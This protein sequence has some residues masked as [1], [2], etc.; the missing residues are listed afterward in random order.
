MMPSAET[1]QG[2][3]VRF[4]PERDTERGG[5][6][7][8]C[9][10][11]VASMHGL[12]VSADRL[13]AG[14]P[15][16]N[17]VL[18]PSCL[19]RD[20]ARAGMVAR[21]VR[22]PL[23]KLNA[24]L[25]PIIL[26]LSENS[27]C[28]LLSLDS[29]AGTARALFPE[30][31]EGE[32]AL[33]LEELEARYSGY[34][35]YIKPVFRF[36]ERAPSYK[37]DRS[38]NWFW[39]SIS[40]NRTLYRDVITASAIG[41]IFALAMP[42]FTMNVYN[43]IIP[44]RAMNSLWVTAIGVLIM[45]TA[46]FLLN[47]TRSRLV[48]NAA[49]RT[50]AKLSA[51]LMEQIL[52]LKAAD[53]PPSVGSFANVIQG[54][55]S[56]RNFI[57]SATLFAYVDLPFSIFFLVVIAIIAWPLA[58]PLAVG[59]FLILLHAALIQGTMRDLAETTNRASALKNATLIESLVGMETVKSQGAESHVQMRWERAVSFLELT[60]TRLRLLSGS[61]ISGIQWVQQS[62]SVI[63]MIVGV[64]LVVSN[65]LSMGALI[66]VSM[67][68]SRCIAPVG[69]AAGLMMQYHSASRSLAALDGI[70]RKETERP[71]ESA[72]LTRPHLEGDVELRGVTFTYP[73]QERPALSGVSFRIARGERVALV[74]RVGSGKS[75]VSKLI[76]G[77]Y[78]PQEGTVLLDGAD[79]RSI[80]PAEIRRNVASVPQDVTLFFGTLKENLMFGNPPR[81]DDEIL[82]AAEA[83]GVDRFANLHPRGFDMQVGERGECLSSGQRQTIAVARALLKHAPILL[84]DEPTASMDNA[85]EDHVRAHLASF[86]ADRTL[87]L[88]TH[89]T[90]LLELVDRIIVLDE[91]R[92]V[93]DGPKGEVLNALYR[94]KP[95][96][97]R[98][99]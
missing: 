6:L 77:L 42:L 35:F 10:L 52:A 76:L 16:E 56:V 90:A 25:A 86:V 23:R 9:L 95:K 4:E 54:F 67:L 51:L 69:K 70:M 55:E 1:P 99:A 81:G 22:A 73:G 97:E 3:D 5:P 26:I 89:R 87:L 17:D 37:R 60:N 39:S 59:S 49:A 15:L 31:G 53:R 38:A 45:V 64:Y 8:F 27:A 18:V 24:A 46:D 63:T 2:Q 88:V 7:A 96:L 80:D 71:A 21:A 61:V 78:Q 72:F 84:L 91:G 94:S 13:L 20:A 34:A 92:V 47:A 33:S 32:A 85:T 57:S 30:L 36:D 40:E 93:A 50:N 66:A 79:I 65:N 62:V 41:N 12:S 68:S 14:L 58:I 48:D 74:G 44:N 83:A 11:R 19:D 82:R 29:R 75:T 43:R 28:V 98:G